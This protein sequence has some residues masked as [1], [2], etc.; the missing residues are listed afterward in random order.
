MR[1]SR[2]W[3]M[4]RPLRRLAGGDV[5]QAAAPGPGTAWAEAVVDRE[6]YLATYP[7]VRDAG[8]DPVEHYAVHGR[9]QGRL[10]RPPAEE[11]GYS[12]TAG[13]D[14]IAEV[15]NPSGSDTSPPR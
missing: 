5:P 7:D 3:R 13:V 9:E 2:S 8:L 15:S 11:S 6:W 14:E 10:P 4:T 12:E 1:A